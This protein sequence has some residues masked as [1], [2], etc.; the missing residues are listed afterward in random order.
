MV[1]DL[2][3]MLIGVL[4]STTV[5]FRLHTSVLI[6]GSAVHM[7]TTAS[8]RLSTSQHSHLAPEVLA[9]LWVGF[10][11]TPGHWLTPVLQLKEPKAIVSSLYRALPNN[12][13]GQSR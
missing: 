2:S 10:Q 12:P 7:H 4:C 3:D 11:A 6:A 8:T 1:D 5:R 13:A 9:E